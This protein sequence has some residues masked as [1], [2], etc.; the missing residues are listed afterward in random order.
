MKTLRTSMPR[1]RPMAGTFTLIE[2]LVVISIIAVLAALLLPALQQ[3]RRTARAIV[4]TNNLK[5]HGM[6]AG[7]YVGEF[8][9]HFV[10]YKGRGLTYSQASYI[11]LLLEQEGLIQTSAQLAR[12]Q[13]TKVQA[14]EIP[15]YASMWLCPLDDINEKTSTISFR[16]ANL[17]YGSYALPGFAPNP[18]GYAAEM[19]LERRKQYFVGLADV[20][21]KW[22]AAPD[23]LVRFPERT[24]LLAEVYYGGFSNGFV[25]WNGAGPF[26][27]TDA[28]YQAN[29]ARHPSF[30]RNYLHADGHTDA[31]TDAQ[32]NLTRLWRI[33]Q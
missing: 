22:W 24:F 17:Q 29:Y 7:S 21:G 14:Q 15:T 16:Q 30:K 6:A 26:N 32:A 18:S 9:S 25:T 19:L 2:L 20:S 4:C 5:Q 27:R 23:S 33:D 11:D 1:P 8:D 28:F 3:A 12:G 13:W 10:P 31:L